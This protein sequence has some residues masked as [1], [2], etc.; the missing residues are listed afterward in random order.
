[1]VAQGA[2]Q[3][4][5]IQEAIVIPWQGMTVQQQQEM[6]VLREPE[7][8]VPSQL[9]MQPIKLQPD[10]PQ[11]QMAQEPVGHHLQTPSHPRPQVNFDRYELT[12]FILSYQTN[13]FI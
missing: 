13:Y 5:Q 3:I 1:M 11:L 9:K 10:L 8:Q 6:T 12:I 7:P 4:L 2:E